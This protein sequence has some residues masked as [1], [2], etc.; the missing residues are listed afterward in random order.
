[1]KA[2]IPNIQRPEKL[3]YGLCQFGTGGKLLKRLA[4]ESEHTSTPLKR[5][6]HETRDLCGEAREGLVAVPGDPFLFADWHRVL[7]FH[8]VIPPE[9][10]RAHVPPP[11]ELELRNGEACMSIVA[12]TMRNFRPCRF[13]PVALPFGCLREQRFLNLR[14]YVRCHD[15]P[16][17]FFLHGWLTRPL[18]LPL[19]SGFCA[20][21]FTFA[22]SKYEHIPENGMIRGTV[23]AAYRQFSYHAAIPDDQY[24][25]ATPGSLAQFVME[26]YSGFFCRKGKGYVFRAR[27]PIWLQR[28][29]DATIEEDDLITIEFPEWKE[30]RFMGASFA[31][32]FERVEL[33]KAH[34]VTD[35]PR[36]NG[37]H[38][39]LS[40]LFEMP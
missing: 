26:R 27:H 19:P 24:Q 31:P 38:R 9:A 18:G 37:G 32:G 25:P 30:A 35:T 16:G 23:S 20:L 40:R 7:F 34:T 21:P 13:D 8:F 2:P 36:R 39:V 5:R 12:V 10:L 3:Q 11:F 4:V 17:A 22:T 29:V 14:T 1:M 15:E 6:V 28:A 33:G